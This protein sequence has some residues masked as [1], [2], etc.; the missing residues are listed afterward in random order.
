[1]EKITKR[2]YLQKPFYEWFSR[3]MTEYF[4]E[5]EHYFDFE[6]NQFNMN[7]FNKNF[8]EPYEKV[9]TELF[10]QIAEMQ[11]ALVSHRLNKKFI[12]KIVPI[13][14]SDAC[15]ALVWTLLQVDYLKFFEIMEQ[16]ELSEAEH[17]E[18]LG[19]Y[20]ERYKQCLLCSK[21]NEDEYGNKFDG[22][23]KFC[24]FENRKNPEIKTSLDEYSEDCCSGKWRL[25]YSNLINKISRIENEYQ[26]K[27]QNIDENEKKE[28]IIESFIQFCE[29]LFEHNLNNRYIVQT[30]ETPAKLIEAFK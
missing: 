15:N 6:N 26:V 25:W 24:F 1:M 12:F 28:R 18:L 10:D 27:H 23:T 29:E 4:K 30:K 13:K 17:D 20:D 21:P 5:N 19:Y 9:P 8:V 14:E 2:L 3:K 11:T 7:D 16:G 22:R